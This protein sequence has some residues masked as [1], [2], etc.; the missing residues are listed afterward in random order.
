MKPWWERAVFVERDDGVEYVRG[1]VY[2]A[3]FL[4]TVMAWGVVIKAWMV[5]L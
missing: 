3:V 2:L 5:W 4:F 1:W